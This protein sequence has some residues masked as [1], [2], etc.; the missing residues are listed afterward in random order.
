[1]STDLVDAA[2]LVRFACQPRLTPARNPEYDELVKAWPQRPELR[3]AA[4]AVATGLGLWIVG[5]DRRIGMV[6]S[7]EEDSPF[8]LQLTDFYRAARADA[9]RGLRVA[10][11]VTMLATWRLCYPN[12]RHLDDDDRVPRVSADEVLAYVDGLC[13]RLDAAVAESDESVDPPVDEPDLERSWRSW[14]RRSTTARTP[15]GRRSARTTAAIVARTLEWMVAQGLLEQKSDEEGGTYQARPRL[16]LLVRAVAG[17][18]LYAE[19]VRLGTGL[20][21]SND[22]DDPTGAFGGTA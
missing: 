16:R 15:D 22:N 5:V 7:A 10:F 6:C 8:E 17:G 2:R 9:Q 4:E 13:A 3:A 12:P 19:V 20:A 18:D 21:G 14:M 11:G 1:M